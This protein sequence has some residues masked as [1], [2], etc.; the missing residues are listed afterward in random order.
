MIEIRNVENI[1]L[2]DWQNLLSHSPT[3]SY[4]QSPEFF[5]FFSSLSFLETFGWGVFENKN[6]KALVCGYIIANGGKFKRYFSRRA[7]IHGGLLLAEDV[8]HKHISTLIDVLK[9]ELSDKAI[10][11]EIRNNSNFSQYKTV[12][13]EIGFEYHSHLNYKVNT[14]DIDSVKSRYS[15]SKIRQ[16]KKSKEQGVIFKLATTQ[17][18]IDEFYH[19]LSDL[20][21]YKIKK[22]LFPVEFFE[23]FLQQPNCYLFVVIINEKVIGGIACAAL[24]DKALYE[25]FVCGNTEDY[26]HLYPSVFATHKGIEFAVTN[27]FE[28]FDFMGAGKP[29]VEYGVRDFKEKFGGE[30]YELGRFRFVSNKLLYSI[31]KFAINKLKT[32]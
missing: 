14:C 9:K 24:P 7:I 19:I 25:W 6:L 21:K 13:Q 31:G 20:Y 2:S 18:D 26:N 15:E 17:R 16:I 8:G 23:K 30:L 11:I 5:D 3:A 12:F 10:Y 29:D 22:P 27:G 4:F 28:H 32:I 1:A